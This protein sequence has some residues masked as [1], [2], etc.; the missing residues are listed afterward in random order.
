MNNTSETMPKYMT[1]K[2]WVSKFGYFPE[3]GLRH[4]IF[5]NPSF[6]QRVVKRVGKKVLLDVQ[7]LE[8]WIGEQQQDFDCQLPPTK[9]G[10]L[11]RQA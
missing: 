8:N 4:L 7:A 10:S 11:S 5:S 6:N 3:G 2:Q 9:V 1:I